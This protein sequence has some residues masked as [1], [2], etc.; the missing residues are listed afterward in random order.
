[1]KKV[2]L[3]A[4]LLFTS[5]SLQAQSPQGLE[6]NTKLLE[7]ISPQDLESLA[8]I[9]EQLPEEDLKILEGGSEANCLYCNFMNKE[10][11]STIGMFLKF[12][13]SGCCLIPFLI[14]LF[15]SCSVCCHEDF[16]QCC[17]DNNGCC[18]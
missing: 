2:M 3:F 4:V 6:P 1:M 10:Q 7:Q 14:E 5:I 15:R 13:G 17:K 8:Q 12:L 11:K 16:K 18:V 9:L